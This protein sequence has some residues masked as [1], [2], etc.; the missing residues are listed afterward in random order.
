MTQQLECA[1]NSFLV[2]FPTLTFSWGGQ[3]SNTALETEII[4]VWL[5]QA[6]WCFLNELSNYWE[7]RVL[8]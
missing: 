6:K 4:C 1:G 7:R 3:G 5:P 8:S 2:I